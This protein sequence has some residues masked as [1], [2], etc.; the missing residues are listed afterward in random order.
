MDLTGR[1][2]DGGRE[3]DLG[4][5]AMPARATVA[6]MSR[7]DNPAEAWQLAERLA[8]VQRRISSLAADGDVRLWLQQRLLSVTAAVRARQ[9]NVA[10]CHRRLDRLIADVERAESR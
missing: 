5:A 7:A 4:V 9:A 1:P 10:G 2:C 6:G 3:R 8:A